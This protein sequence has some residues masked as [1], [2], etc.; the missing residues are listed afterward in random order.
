[1][2]LATE[3]TPELVR[4]G[5]SRDLVRFVQD[6]RKELDLERTDRINVVIATDSDELKQAIDENSDYIS[7]ETLATSLKVVPFAEATADSIEKEIGE[8]AFKLH[9]T[10]A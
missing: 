5:L 3:L 7:G 8:H 6:R 1:V 4:A 2:V 10:K 9:V